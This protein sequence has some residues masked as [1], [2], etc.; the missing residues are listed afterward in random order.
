MT[1]IEN[2][3]KKQPVP[4]AV[5][6]TVSV[7]LV[8]KHNQ[9]V[10]LLEFRGFTLSLAGAAASIIFVATKVCLSWQKY[11]VTTNIF[12]WWQKVLWWQAYLCHDKRCV[13]LWQ[14]CVCRDKSMLVAIKLVVT[15]WC[16]LRQIFVVTST[17]FV[18]TIFV[19]VTKM[20]LVAAPTNE[21]TC[22]GVNVPCVY[23]HPRWELL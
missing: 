14:R 16:S 23:I 7:F 22:G 10:V 2:I 6:I 5:W 18:V 3:N 9:V 4:I 20:I 19:V 8:L 1:G 21:S 13:L 17:C 12:L 15:K 11:F